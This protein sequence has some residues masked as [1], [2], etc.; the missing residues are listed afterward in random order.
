M[1]E[2]R[3]VIEGEFYHIIEE[4]GNQKYEH[5]GFRDKENKFGSTMASIVPEVGMTKKAKLIVELGE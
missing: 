5:I 2:K 3:I 1:V 4:L